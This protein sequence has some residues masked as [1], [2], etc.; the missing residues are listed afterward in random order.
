MASRSL[1]G[2]G[3]NRGGGGGGGRKS[4]SARNAAVERRNLIT[5]C[6]YGAARRL[7]EERGPPAPRAQGWGERE[8]LGVPEITGCSPG[9]YRAGRVRGPERPERGRSGYR[10]GPRLSI[11]FSAGSS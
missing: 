9:R 7:G 4:L 10:Q 6:R 5:V 11:N 2:L 3:G 1:R 8:P